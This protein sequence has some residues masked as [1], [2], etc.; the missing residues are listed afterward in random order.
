[1]T[2]RAFL[3]ILASIA[4]GAAALI[5]ARESGLERLRKAVRK[6]EGLGRAPVDRLHD[7]YAWLAVEPSAFERY[8]TDYERHFGWLGRFS[9]SRS[10]FFTR[11]LLCTNFFTNAS[12]REGEPVRYA[13]FYEPTTSPC[14]NPLANRPPSDAELTSARPLR[15]RGA[16]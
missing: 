11:F 14:Y 4:A 9:I 15:L 13:I 5:V 16:A 6:L 10:D 8:V 12:A 2:R 7:H 1:V 3:A